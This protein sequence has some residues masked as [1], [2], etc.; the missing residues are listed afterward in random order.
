MLK[1]LAALGAK[2]CLLT[3]VGF[4]EGMTGVMGYDSAKDEFCYY[5]HKKQPISYHGTGD[6]YSSTCVG[7]MMNGFPW[8]EAMRIAA[9]YTAECIRITYE[10]KGGAWYGVHFEQAI[11]YL[12]KL[13]NK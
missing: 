6:I 10:E 1:R 9:D 8:Q 11:P 7:A 12:L 3:G 4:R 13:L 2:V 5:E